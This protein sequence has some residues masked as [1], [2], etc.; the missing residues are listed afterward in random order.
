MLFSRLGRFAH[1]AVWLLAFSLALVLLAHPAGAQDADGD[2]AS[3]TPA[4]QTEVHGILLEEEGLP[5]RNDSPRAAMYTFL[6]GLAYADDAAR[7]D[8]ERMKDEYLGR[9]VETLDL[10]SFV[11]GTRAR[12][13]E[14]LAL[15]LKS[16]VLDKLR[17]VEFAEISGDPNESAPYTI[18]VTPMG[19]PVELG[20]GEDGQWRFTRRTVDSIDE[21]AREL[22]NQPVLGEVQRLDTLVAS[23]EWLRM[24]MPDFMRQQ[25]LVLYLYQWIGIALLAFVAL[26]VG[27]ALVYLIVFL[28]ERR[29]D[30]MG[31][32]EEA[33]KTP[34]LNWPLGFVFAV[35]IWWWLEPWL[36]LPPGAG[37]VA[38]NIAVV[39]FGVGMI[40]FLIRMTNV[41][42]D[43]LARWADKTPSKYDNLLVPFVRKTAK[44]IV[45]LVGVMMVLDNLGVNLTAALGTLAVGGL[46]ISLA[47][48][49]TVANVFG[50]LTVIID[51]PFHIGDWVVIEGHEGTVESLGF[52]STRVRTF[53][54]SV[55]TI[56]NSHMISAV[57]DNYG[58]RAYRRYSC[59]YGIT[60]NT[61]P[62][63]VEAFCEGL[64]ELVRQHPYT[65]KDFFHIYFHNF[66]D[67][68][69]DILV[70]IFFKTGDWGTELRERHRFNVDSLRLAKR[71]GIEFAFPTQTLYLERG[72]GPAK[73]D[74]SPVVP[75]DGV[76]DLIDSAMDSAEE[77]VRA[78]TGPRGYIPPPVTTEAPKR[79]G[80]RRAMIEGS[81]G[82]GAS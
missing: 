34:L 78:T 44:T 67:H 71:L 29:L 1:R 57:V 22:A 52:R 74:P 48:K 36:G 53:Y 31:I 63:R 45:F 59:H 50:T 68:S 80:K 58:M 66:G 64:R 76:D 82:E 23:S 46:A 12:R 9:V 20:P 73:P 72:Q 4:A 37:R 49:E 41:A 38:D 51:R 26:V 60:Y 18:A 19:R 13:G 61:P 56:P 21:M 10:S 6:R 5:P 32:P 17:F 62:E 79:D 16:D 3:P 24:R 81:A 39:V 25:Y 65:R 28:L 35:I 11:P 77:I 54:N 40:V 7:L 2:S 27:R 14:E 69:L 55:I 70:Y 15:R 8:D 42:T 47:G 43:R 30:M 33:R 75:K